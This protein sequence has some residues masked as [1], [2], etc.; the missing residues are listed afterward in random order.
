M[1][2]YNV[3][4]IFLAIPVRSLWVDG[5]VASQGSELRSL[6]APVVAEEPPNC[7][8]DV[9]DFAGKDY[10]WFILN[11]TVEHKWSSGVLIRG[12]QGPLPFFSTL[13]LLLLVDKN[14]RPYDVGM[15][16]SGY[17]NRFYA[18]PLGMSADISFSIPEVNHVGGET[19]GNRMELEFAVQLFTTVT[20]PTIGRVNATEVSKALA[21][22]D[23]TDGESGVTVD[24][25]AVGEAP[26]SGW[27]SEIH[28]HAGISGTGLKSWLYE[29]SVEIY[30]SYHEHDLTINYDKRFPIFSVESNL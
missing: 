16:A 8:P 3:A 17:T 24:I 6:R 30:I 15:W 7:L 2:S 29:S 10:C 27:Y 28:F 26:G 14:W 9:S 19:S 1:F 21:Y 4:V 25:T 18:L 22:V 11:D 12:T 13:Q 20:I 5:V 23:K